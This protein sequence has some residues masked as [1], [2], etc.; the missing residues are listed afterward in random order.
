[1][2][3]RGLRTGRVMGLAISLTPAWP[4]APVFAPDIRGVP[5]PSTF[6]RGHPGAPRV[7]D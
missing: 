3:G 2:V 4:E 7:G 1:M 5:A 6:G